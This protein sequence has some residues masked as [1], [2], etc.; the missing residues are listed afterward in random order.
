MKALRSEEE[1]LQQSLLRMDFEEMKR[2]FGGKDPLWR[3]AEVLSDS[4]KADPGREGKLQASLDR[5]SHAL[6]D[7]R[8]RNEERMSSLSEK[9]R[10]QDLPSSE[11]CPQRVVPHVPGGKRTRPRSASVGR[12]APSGA[13]RGV[14][15]VA[16]VVTSTA[17]RSGS[18][19]GRS[20]IAHG[21]PNRG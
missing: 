12:T 4:F 18:A 5:L 1:A 17:A 10:N 7:L 3:G 16:A 8:A 19:Q 20:R 6:A 2:Q 14:T 9:D 11:S 13:R 21:G 15:S